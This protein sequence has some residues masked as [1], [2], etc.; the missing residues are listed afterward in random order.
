MQCKSLLEGRGD[1]QPPTICLANLGQGAF[2]SSGEWYGSMR[3]L[4]RDPPLSDHVHRKIQALEQAL[5][6][7]QVTPYLSPCG[8]G[9][10]G[11]LSTLGILTV[12][13]RRPCWCGTETET[14]AGREI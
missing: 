5:S 2:I 4:E 7:E 1:V 9:W 13:V 6:S 3:V 14:H 8:W 11:P 12:P 10:T